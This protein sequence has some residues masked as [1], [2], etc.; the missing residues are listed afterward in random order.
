L[1]MA[2]IYANLT[3]GVVILAIVIS[4]GLVGRRL[5]ERLRL[6]MVPRLSIILTI[7]ILCFVFGVSALHYLLP[8]VSAE[9]VLLPMIILTTLIERFHV[10]AEEDGLAYT[11]QLALGTLLVS[12]LCYL[13]L[14]W[15]RV[16]QTVLTYPEIHFLTIAVFIMMGR[17]AGYRLTE[18]WRFRD[19]VHQAEPA[20]GEY[21]HAGRSPGRLSCTPA[22]SSVSTSGT[23]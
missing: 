16:G 3:T 11:V 9:V 10:T 6:L 14:M 5:L 12:V 2:F 1:A 22:V 7:V 19:L 17:Y 20:R 13:V 4:V 23:C 15:E 8:A 21:F 18:L